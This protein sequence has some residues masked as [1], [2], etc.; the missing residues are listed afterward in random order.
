MLAVA[1]TCAQA[2]IARPRI[3]GILFPYFVRS[4]FYDH[5]FF[6]ELQ[7]WQHLFWNL[8]GESVES[9]LQ[10]VRDLSPTVYMQTKRRNRRKC[11]YPYVLDVQN[12]IQLVIV[13]LRMYPEIS[14]LSGMFMPSP[15]TVQ[16]HTSSTSRTMALFQGPREMAN[17]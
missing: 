6:N 11:D 10:I 4:Q 15:T 3:E 2:G 9:F 8:T 5:D 7:Q 17:T 14:V 12:R 1:A 13:G 16:R